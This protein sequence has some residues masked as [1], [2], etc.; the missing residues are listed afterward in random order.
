MPPTLLPFP[1]VC[2]LPSNRILARASLTSWRRSRFALATW[3]TKRSISFNIQRTQAQFARMWTLRRLQQL[4]GIKFTPRFPVM[5]E[6]ERL[7]EW[8]PNDRQNRCGQHQPTWP[9]RNASIANWI[10]WRGWVDNVLRDFPDKN[11]TTEDP[12]QMC[13][14]ARKWTVRAK[15]NAYSSQSS[16][17]FSS[18]MKP[19]EC[20][21]KQSFR[22][23][24][25]N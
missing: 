10:A 23:W 16:L 1:V 13:L 24:H 7:A 21:L 2:V 8:W 6:P 9:C 14:V 25:W 12:I 20:T 17:L 3:A 11:E 18:C 5:S 4:Q 15:N 22:I 19:V